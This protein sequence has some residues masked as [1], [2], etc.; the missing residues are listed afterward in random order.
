MT[1]V[2][3]TGWNCNPEGGDASYVF[4]ALVG[5]IYGSTMY[6][7]YS[8]YDYASQSMR[9]GGRSCVIPPQS[10]AECRF[11]VPVAL[12]GTGNGSSPLALDIWAVM[13]EGDN[14]NRS[15][16]F[17]LTIEHK[18]TVYEGE[19]DAII[20][21]AEAQVSDTELLVSSACNGAV[22]C[23]LASSA[24]RLNV[25]RPSL[26]LARTQ[27]AACQL[28]SAVAS[29]GA[30]ST[31]IRNATSTYELLYPGCAYA[32]ELHKRAASNISSANLTL[33]RQAV[34]GANVTSAR[35]LLEKAQADYVSAGKEIQLDRYELANEYSLNA[36]AKAQNSTGSGGDCPRPTQPPPAAIETPTAIPSATAQAPEPSGG[37]SFAG[38]SGVLGY[39]LL[40]LLIVIL[41]GAFYFMLGKPMMEGKPRKPAPDFTTPRLEEGPRPRAPPTKLDHSKIDR[42]FQEWLKETEEKGRE[43]EERAPRRAPT[44]APPAKPR[45]QKPSA[46]PQ[47]KAKQRKG[48]K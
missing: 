16:R 27:L 41:V 19:V 7:N 13:L 44:R 2:A 9:D 1:Q 11:D 39:G 32:L 15:K 20:A 35:A 30:A 12:G 18:E 24:Q 5:N 14:V 6:V 3:A 34:C 21:A 17:N 10:N 31:G 33:L 22:C 42:E 43:R 48:R 4:R 47:R 37:V 40:A 38:V 45:A 23:G 8:Y 28:A 26:A 29:A 25:A 46:K 36:S